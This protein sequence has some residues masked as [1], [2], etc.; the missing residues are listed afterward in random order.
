MPYYY[1]LAVK[2]GIDEDNF[3][4]EYDVCLLDRK[5]PKELCCGNERMCGNV[6]I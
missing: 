1:D 4:Q 6:R 5:C 2:L 3:G